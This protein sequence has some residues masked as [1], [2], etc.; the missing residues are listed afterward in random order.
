MQRWSVLR[1]VPCETVRCFGL[2]VAVLRRHCMHCDMSTAAS[3][4]RFEQEAK[5]C[6][7]A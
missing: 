5:R 7:S 1:E 6:I 3:L 2:S 4:D